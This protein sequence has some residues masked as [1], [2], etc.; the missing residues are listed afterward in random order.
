MITMP[1]ADSHVERTL[2]E[3][4]TELAYECKTHTTQTSPH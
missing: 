3:D 2:Q 1:N 4:N